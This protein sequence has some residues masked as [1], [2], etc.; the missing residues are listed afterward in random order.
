MPVDDCLACDGACCACFEW[1]QVDPEYLAA[2]AR[3]L[4]STTD[5]LIAR[6]DLKWAEGTARRP[7]E[8]ERRTLLLHLRPH[9][10]F[11]RDGRCS[12]HPARPKAC[13]DFPAGSDACHT[14]QE[15][16]R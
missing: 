13:R 4:G 9:C 10:P 15:T 12:I 1:L 16:R 11:L 2:M 8:S 14:A 7:G 5:E 6:P 3:A